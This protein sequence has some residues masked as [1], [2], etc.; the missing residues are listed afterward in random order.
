MKK[1]KNEKEFSQTKNIS[2]GHNFIISTLI[3]LKSVGKDAYFSVEQLWFFF[4]EFYEFYNSQ[5]I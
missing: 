4:C 3:K 2:N 1:R 5:K